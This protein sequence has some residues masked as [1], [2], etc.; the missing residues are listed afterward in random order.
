MKELASGVEGVRAQSDQ[1]A[2]AA[3][4]QARTMTE[5]SKASELTAREIRSIVSANKQQSAGAKRLVSQLSDVRL[6]TQRNAEGVGRT[7]GDTAD[8]LK[9]AEAL[10][11][12]MAQARPNGRG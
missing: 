8:L 4:E 3:K 12:L 1:A 6:I 5:I 7:R 2:R 10:S 11:G 9:Q